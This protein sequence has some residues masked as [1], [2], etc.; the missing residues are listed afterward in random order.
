M[1]P[2]G[3]SSHIYDVGEPSRLIQK[4]VTLDIASI[5]DDYSNDWSILSGYYNTK[6]KRVMGFG[7]LNLHIYDVNESY[8]L[9][10]TVRHMIPWSTNHQGIMDTTGI[11]NGSL[12]LT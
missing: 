2:G 12:M 6:T 3:L 5:M 7:G 4:N 8:Q 1:S 11:I 9:H 10:H